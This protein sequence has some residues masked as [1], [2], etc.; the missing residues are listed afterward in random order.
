MLCVYSHTH[1]FIYSCQLFQKCLSTLPFNLH[2]LHEFVD[3]F[4]GCYKDGTD[5]GTLDCWWFSAVFLLTRLLTFLAYAVTL[6]MMYFIYGSIFLLILLI[7]TI[8]IQPFKKV[9]VHYPSTDSIFL[10]FSVILHITLLGRTIT[11][12]HQDTYYIIMTLL[13]NFVIVPMIYISF[14]IGLW[15]VSRRRWINTI[16]NRIQS[17]D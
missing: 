3:S 17:K 8:N 12:M 7:A 6:S 11:S 15:F 13:I 5:P 4:Q 10:I 2:F 9:V 14:L 1:F 16:M